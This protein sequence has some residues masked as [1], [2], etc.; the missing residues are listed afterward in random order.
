MYGH[1][2]LTSFPARMPQVSTFLSVLCSALTRNF[3]GR[4]AGMITSRKPNLFP[5]VVPILVK[6]SNV[7]GLVLLSNDGT[8]GLKKNWIRI[9]M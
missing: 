8:D 2:L 7:G 5:L 4:S 1:F 3:L 9:E 6:C